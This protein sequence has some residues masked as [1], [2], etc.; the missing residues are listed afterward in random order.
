[1]RRSK[2]FRQTGPGLAV[3]A[4]LAGMGMPVAN[5]AGLE[6]T[7]MGRDDF[8]WA[9]SGYVRAWASMNLEDQPE[10]S[11]VGKDSFGKLSMLRGSL[12]LDL[13]VKT[14]PVKWKAIG[15]LDREYKTNYLSDLEELRADGTANAFGVNSN[16]DSRSITEN[17]NNGEIREFWAE[18]PIGERVT[19]KFGKQQLVWGESDF[20]QAMDL[21]HGYDYSW[22]L[23]FEGE[24]EEWRKPLILLSTKIRIPEA[25]GLIAAYIRP[26][27]DRCE[28]IGNTYD[29]NGGRWF[30]QPY[31]GFDLSSGTSKNCEHKDGD[32][33]DVTGGIRWNGEAYGLNYSVAYLTTFAADPVASAGVVPGLFGAVAHQGV[34]NG[35]QLFQRIHPKIDVLGVTVSGYSETLDAVLSAEVA[36]TK[37]QPYNAGVGGFGEGNYITRGGGVCTA[38]LGLCEI[39]KKDTLRTMLRIDKDL[40]FQDLLGTSRPSFSSIQLFNTQVLNYDGNEQLVRLFA[41]GTP[42]NEHNTIL[43]LFTGLNYKND[44]INPGFAVGF[45][46]SNGG[47]FAIPSVSVVFDDKWVAK[48]EA[49]IFWDGGKSNRQ[50]FSGGESQLFGYFSRA[51][52]LV[53]RVTRQF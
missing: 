5:A 42:L 11:R 43:T 7:W 52:Q 51:S 23:F 17:Y 50:Q 40:N 48:A 53:L 29:I 32:Q 12:L 25:N 14:G 33:D 24:N 38:G 49:D 30:F 8:T 4:V 37:D 28:D 2:I 22:R 36:Y 21:V 10:L 18:V 44:T 27:W 47:G 45:D 41:Y 20:F 26:G 46:L 35:E 3:A 16:R 19:V 15:R 34:T 9:L 6:G 13:D 31:R 1:M 39:V